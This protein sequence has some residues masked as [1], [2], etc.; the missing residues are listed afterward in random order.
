MTSVSSK[1]REDGKNTSRDDGENHSETKNSETKNSETKSPK[2]S[3]DGRSAKS[4]TVTVRLTSWKDKDGEGCQCPEVM[5]SVRGLRDFLVT[6]HV[7]ILENISIA[8][9]SGL[10]ACP[11]ALWCPEDGDSIMK[12]EIREDAGESSDAW[13]IMD[14]RVLYD[15]YFTSH[16]REEGDAE[17]INDEHIGD[18]LVS[19]DGYDALF[20]GYSEGERNAFSE[21]LQYFKDH[22]GSDVE[23]QTISENGRFLTRGEEYELDLEEMLEKEFP[24]LLNVDDGDDEDSIPELIDSDE[25][26]DGEDDEDEEVY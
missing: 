3:L 7:S 23:Y 8:Y 4:K 6:E 18:M 2:T 22:I 13:K 21:G 24:E 17:L 12:I 20:Y 19:Y 5:H 9:F 25:D 26:D 14:G 1:G 10:A 15:T 11:Y 16:R